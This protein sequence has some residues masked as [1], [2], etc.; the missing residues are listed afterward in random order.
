MKHRGWWLAN[1]V[2]AVL[3]ISGG[4]WLMVR[5]V[6]G[7]GHSEDAGSRLLALGVLGAFAAGVILI[8]LVVYW[9]AKRRK[10]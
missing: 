9:V 1:G 3:V 4:L 2:F 5:Q 10:R 7:T 8:E 6:D